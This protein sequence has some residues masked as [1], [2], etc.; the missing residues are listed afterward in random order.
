[1][2]IHVGADRVRGRWKMRRR[3]RVGGGRRKRRGAGGGRGVKK[4]EG[5]EKEQS[6]RARS[7]RR[8]EKRGGR[9]GGGRGRGLPLYP[10][11]HTCE[12]DFKRFKT[13]EARLIY[14][15]TKCQNIVTRGNYPNFFPRIEEDYHVSMSYTEKSMYLYNLQNSIISL[16]L[17]TEKGINRHNPMFISIFMFPK[18]LF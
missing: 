10:P 13:G 7:A 15:Q 9:Q 18:S 6:L 1:M 16:R 4:G 14:E 12:L 17:N 11:P 5:G 3:E 2:Y 8:S